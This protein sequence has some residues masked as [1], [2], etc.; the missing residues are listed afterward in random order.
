MVDQTK[1]RYPAKSHKEFEEHEDFA[2]KIEVP[3][4]GINA[5]GSDKSSVKTR[6]ELENSTRNDSTDPEAPEVHSPQDLEAP[7][8]DQAKKGS[9]PEEKLSSI[10]PKIEDRSINERYVD[11]IHGVGKRRHS[12]RCPSCGEFSLHR[13]HARNMAESLR[14]KLSSKRIFRCH[15]CDWRGWVHKSF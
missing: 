7:E 4:V 6:N 14:K 5:I 3:D 10:F 15:E 13:S 11:K 8:E 1:L 12:T 9:D 2:S